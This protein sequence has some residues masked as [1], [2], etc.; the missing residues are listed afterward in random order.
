MYN[1]IKQAMD[2][3]PTGRFVRH[4]LPQLVLVPDTCIFQ[5]WLMPLALQLKTGCVIDRDY[6]TP[7]VDIEIAMR[8]ARARLFAV[9][10]SP[11][12]QMQIKQIVKKHA[13]RKGLPGSNRDAKGK[14]RTK[15]MKTP[16]LSLF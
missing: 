15:K 6:P 3:D 4:W 1:P 14:E 16:Q 5:P 2:Q 13:S 9:L 10:R 8:E 7:I 11:E 12:A